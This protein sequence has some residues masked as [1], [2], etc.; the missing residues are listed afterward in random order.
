[1]DCSINASG[2]LSGAN[3]TYHKSIGM[4]DLLET[5][6]GKIYVP[7]T[8][9]GQHEWLRLMGRSVE[10]N[11][12]RHVFDIISER[13]RGVAIDGGASFGC[14]TLALAQH[15][16]VEKVIAFEPQHVIRELLYRSIKENDLRNVTVVACGLGT[17]AGHEIMPLLNLDK[18]TNFGGIALGH[19]HAEHPDAPTQLVKIAPLDDF[20]SVSE[21][22]S[23][24]KLDLEG[25][26]L[27]ALQGAIRT[28][29]RCKPVI[30]MET[31][32]SE[33]NKKVLLDYVSTW[34]YAVEQLGP[35]ALCIP[36]E[37][38]REAQ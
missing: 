5:H 14:W 35:N 26:E 33:T 12:I 11:F 16:A 22:V 36:I 6:Y 15:K 29:N 4:I 7:N 8:D 21:R 38:E 2:R 31:D 10:E 23:F 34:N 30:F 1:M 18:P 32:H 19:A 25:H 17:A 13:P 24:I 37:Y 27:Q 20:V 3:G 28:I 9:I